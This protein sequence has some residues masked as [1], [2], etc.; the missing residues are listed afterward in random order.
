MSYQSKNVDNQHREI[1]STPEMCTG[2]GSTDEIIREKTQENFIP[3]VEAY[4][5]F[6]PI[7]EQKGIRQLHHDKKHIVFFCN[8]IDIRSKIYFVFL[9]NIS[10]LIFWDTGFWF[11]V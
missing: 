10:F 3:Y 5:E 4:Y 11:Y 6:T 8:C 1:F 7:Y 2:E 9:H